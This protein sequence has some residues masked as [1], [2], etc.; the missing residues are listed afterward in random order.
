[1][2]D[3]EKFSKALDEDALPHYSMNCAKFVDKALEAAGLDIHFHPG[4]AR[5]YGPYLIGL[6]FHEVSDMGYSPEVGD[7]VVIQPSNH[8][9]AAKISPDGH[10]AGYDGHQWISDFR[11]IDMWGGPYRSAH[12]SYQIYRHN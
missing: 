4:V 6:G 8:P 10:V 11:Q 12:L 1:M 7:I 9:E 2:F 5:D 3:K